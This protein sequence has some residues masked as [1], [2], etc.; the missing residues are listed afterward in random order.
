VR[1]TVLGS[2]RPGAQHQRRTSAEVEGGRWSAAAVAAPRRLCERSG[3]VYADVQQ[4]ERPPRPRHFPR[5]ERRPGPRSHQE[6]LAEVLAVLEARDMEL[7]SIKPSS[8]P[9][10]RSW[11][12]S[13]RC[14]RP[15]TS[16]WLRCCPSWPRAEEEIAA[17]KVALRERRPG[18]A[19]GML[20]A[21]TKGARDAIKKL[22]GA[23]R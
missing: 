7:A 12:T 14:W 8:P 19:R 11:T 10:T 15:A 6:Q 13:R 21:I 2:P 9:A 5:R 16:S 1:E 23:G 22:V 17:L 3:P 20:A 4:R 18:P